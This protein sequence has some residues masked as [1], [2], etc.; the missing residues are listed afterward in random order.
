MRYHRKSFIFKSNDDEVMQWIVEQT[1][2]TQS[3]I[4]RISMRLLRDAILFDKLGKYE[5]IFSG[6]KAINELDN[7]VSSNTD[8]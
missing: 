2:F 6:I 8:A 4:V 1:G 5:S 7:L 3:D